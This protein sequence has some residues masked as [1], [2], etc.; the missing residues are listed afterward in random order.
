[1]LEEVG[2]K[3]LYWFTVAKKTDL[4]A[5]LFPLKIPAPSL[6]SH[7]TVGKLTKLIY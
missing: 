7:M 3:E 4:G 2:S 6:T 5:K 1:M